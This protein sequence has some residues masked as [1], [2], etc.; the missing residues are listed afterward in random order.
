MSPLCQAVSRGGVTVQIEIYEDGEGDWI[1]EAVDEYRNST[2]WDD[3]FPS[4]EDAL[5]EA[6]NT[7]ESEGISVLV[8]ESK[9][10][11]H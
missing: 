1:L 8:G 5:K 7:I 2:V 11:L 3:R 10:V 4:D 6:M 9:D